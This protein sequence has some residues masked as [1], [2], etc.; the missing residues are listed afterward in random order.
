MSFGIDTNGSGV[1]AL[2]E[3]ARIFKKI[4]DSFGSYAQ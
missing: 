3:I 2:L 1:I 4:F